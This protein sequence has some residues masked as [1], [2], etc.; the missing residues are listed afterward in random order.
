MLPGAAQASMHEAFMGG[1]RQAAGM[2]LACSDS[3]SKFSAA[4]D[5]GLP[6]AYL[7]LQNDVPRKEEPMLM[8]VRLTQLCAH[9]H[10]QTHAREAHEGCGLGGG[11]G[12]VEATSGFALGGKRRRSD[13]VGSHPNS[14]PWRSKAS[15]CWS[16]GRRR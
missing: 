7:V 9:A 16:K 4:Q 6:R 14:M 2:Q 11:G 15:L 5:S 1:A 8:Q 3:S 12:G 10:T 13:K